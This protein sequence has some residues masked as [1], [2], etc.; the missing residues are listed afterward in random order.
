MSLSNLSVALAQ[1]LGG[2]IYAGLANRWSAVPAFYALV[3]VGTLFTAICWLL[4]PLLTRAIAQ[5]G[6][7]D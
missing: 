4:P 2:S 1:G 5:H 6:R 3:A 7:S